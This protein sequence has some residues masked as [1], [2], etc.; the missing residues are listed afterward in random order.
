VRNAMDIIYVYDS[1]LEQE[2]SKTTTYQYPGPNANMKND[3]G[4]NTVEWKEKGEER[5]VHLRAH[6]GILRQDF[7]YKLLCY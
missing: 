3:I 5:V 4:I 7:L 2:T 1:R 6:L